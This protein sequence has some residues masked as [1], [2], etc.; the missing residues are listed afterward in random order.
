MDEMWANLIDSESVKMNNK[1][2]CLK[3][4]AVGFQRSPFD[5]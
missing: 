1:L 4:S 3:V 5:S 2:I